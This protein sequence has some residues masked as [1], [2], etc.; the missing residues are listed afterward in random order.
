MQMAS[1]LKLLA[2]KALVFVAFFW[3]KGKILNCYPAGTPEQTRPG[4]K[5]RTCTVTQ[6]KVNTP[7][8]PRKSLMFF[9]W[10][11]FMP[12]KPQNQPN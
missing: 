7:P 8:P 12:L 5:T 2:Q 10:E 11:I 3:I 9:L 6:Y 4:D 1:I